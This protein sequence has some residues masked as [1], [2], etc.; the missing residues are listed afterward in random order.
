MLT[1]LPFRAGGVSLGVPRKEY[2]VLDVSKLVLPSQFQPDW[3]SRSELSSSENPARVYRPCV[4]DQIARIGNNIEVTI[5]N[6]V[7]SRLWRDE[8][9]DRQTV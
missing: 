8:G 3:S 2:S 4:P 7:L 5:S 9:V 1:Q 6:G